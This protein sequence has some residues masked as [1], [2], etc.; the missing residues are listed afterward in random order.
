M[1]HFIIDLDL[2]YQLELSLK[3][4]LKPDEIIIVSYIKNFPK[5]YFGTI[6]KL[7]ERLGI[8][9]RR[10]YTI[11]DYFLERK[12]LTK[13]NGKYLFVFDFNSI[14]HMHTSVYHMH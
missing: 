8:C 4:R 5:G 6:T 9:R 10:V 12:I 2:I 11:L 3:R 13:E 7:G 1:A 14:H